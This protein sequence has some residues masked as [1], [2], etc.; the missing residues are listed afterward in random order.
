MS[1][2][3]IETICKKLNIEDYRFIM[4][5]NKFAILTVNNR[6]RTL[7]V[8]M[9]DPEYIKDITKRFYFNLV[10][11]MF[12][13]NRVYTDIPKYIP[14]SYIFNYNT[15]KGLEPIKDLQNKSKE[16]CIK[17]LYSIRYTHFTA[18]NMFLVYFPIPI[19]E[20]KLNTVYDS[21]FKYFNDGIL[22]K[23]ILCKL[24][25][26]N[27]IKENKKIINLTGDAKGFILN[28]IKELRPKEF[29]KTHL[30]FSKEYLKYRSVFYYG[31]RINDLWIEYNDDIRNPLNYSQLFYSVEFDKLGIK[32]SINIHTPKE[33]IKEIKDLIKKF[34]ISEQE[35]LQNTVGYLAEY[36]FGYYLSIRF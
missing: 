32:E 19:K 12:E 26:E 8:N 20:I 1:W 5:N 2:K 3:Q 21:F 4:I 9:I 35:F 17:S 22:L 14:A 36:L 31:T 23:E 34:N 16:E 33:A 6:M 24:L 15:N 7:S 18:K 25:F 30:T 27:P 28:L 11:S 13:F 10:S 29:I